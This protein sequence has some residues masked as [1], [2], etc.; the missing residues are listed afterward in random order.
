MFKTLFW[1]FLVQ[2]IV[3]S[4]NAATFTTTPSDDAAATIASTV[5]AS[6][7]VESPGSWKVNNDTI[8]NDAY[9]TTPSDDAAAV[10]I[11]S[12]AIASTIVIVFFWQKTAGAAFASAAAAAKAIQL[13]TTIDA[14][15]NDEGTAATEITQDQATEIYQIQAYLDKYA[16]SIEGMRSFLQKRLNADD[17]L[18][19][20]TM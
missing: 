10:T 6:T 17:I 13:L 18:P 9:I 4:D 1:K 20:K 12:T 3:S 16:T 14:G 7:T 8:P 15:I 11:A 5:I 2:R 19:R